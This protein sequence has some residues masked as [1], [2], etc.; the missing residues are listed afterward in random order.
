MPYTLATYMALK[1]VR[2]SS[3][4][5]RMKVLEYSYKSQIVT[6][7]GLT[8]L[9]TYPFYNVETKNICENYFLTG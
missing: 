3:L 1:F 6:L 8:F 9:N 2:D 4:K 5:T 7:F